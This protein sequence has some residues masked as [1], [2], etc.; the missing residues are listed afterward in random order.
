[1]DP[2]IDQKR[3]AINTYDVNGKNHSIYATGLRNAVGLAFNPTSHELWTAVN[4]RDDLGDNLVP[5][6]VTSVKQS[7]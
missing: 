5:D 4:E 3:A 1:M 6:F 2:E 7:G